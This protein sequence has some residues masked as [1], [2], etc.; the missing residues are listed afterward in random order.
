MG[1]GAGVDPTDNNLK[2]PLCVAIENGR[3]AIAR[4]LIELG[5]D[6][7]SRDTLQ[8]TPLMYACKAGS[9]EAVEMLLQYKADI[10]AVNNLGDS[11]VNLA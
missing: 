6:I 7:E 4:S 3:T 9:K 10:K 8:R 2:T 11:C 1:W 5:S